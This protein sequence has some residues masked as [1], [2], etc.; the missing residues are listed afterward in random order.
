MRK[1]TVEPVPTP[2]TF[3]STTNS[4]AARAAACFPVFCALIELAP[5]FRGL[6][7]HCPLDSGQCLRILS[8]E[9]ESF[10]LAIGTRP[11]ELL[12]LGFLLGLFL[13]FRHGA[14]PVVT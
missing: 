5:L 11:E 8:G 9:R 10:S 12:L 3:P 1:L 4:S 7:R 2:N 13:G 14:S 6:K